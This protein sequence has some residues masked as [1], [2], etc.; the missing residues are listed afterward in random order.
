MNLYVVRHGETN[1][2]KNKL[3]ATEK[4][5]LNNHRKHQ[6]IQLGKKLNK[7]HLD[8]I[9]CSPIERASTPFNY[10]I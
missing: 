4:E 7:L 1:M 10:L 5:P 9:Y 6:A 2:G 3:I 8:L